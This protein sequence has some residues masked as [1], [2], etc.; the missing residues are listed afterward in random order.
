M[1]IL[2]PFPNIYGSKNP[3][4]SL[5]TET[6]I[7]STSAFSKFDLIDDDMVEVHRRFRAFATYLSNETGFLNALTAD[8]LWKSLF[9]KY[10]SCFTSLQSKFE[11]E[12]ATLRAFV[13]EQYARQE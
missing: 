10:E 13:K 3:L 12:T 8:L 7:P 4:D 1:H 9:L 11:R 6:G 5:P 2:A